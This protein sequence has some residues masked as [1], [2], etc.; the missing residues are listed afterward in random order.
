MSEDLHC[1]P[2][3]WLEK[4]FVK[5]INNVSDS[6]HESRVPLHPSDPFVCFSFSHSS[7][8][9]FI[10]KHFFFIFSNDDLTI[11]F[12]YIF[13]SRESQFGEEDPFQK[14]DEFQRKK[15]TFLLAH[16]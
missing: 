1:A 9:H 6:L 8:S 12:I 11:F 10:V 14:W 4:E 13:L 15:I 7:L 5:F 16:G 3:N 2:I